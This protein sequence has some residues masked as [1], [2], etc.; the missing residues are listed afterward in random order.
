[1]GKVFRFKGCGK[2]REI[3]D[4]HGFPLILTF[5]DYGLTIK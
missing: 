2:C 4:F 5:Q 3:I 1:M